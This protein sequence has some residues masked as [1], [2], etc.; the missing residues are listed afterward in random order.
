M[1][2]L[3]MPPVVYRNINRT[4]RQCHSEIVIA[5]DP[6]LYKLKYIKQMRF[7]RSELGHAYSTMSTT[8]FAERTLENIKS[9]RFFIE[10][11]SHY[12]IIIL[13]VYLPFCH[14][15]NLTVIKFIIIRVDAAFL[16][17]FIYSTFGTSMYKIAPPYIQI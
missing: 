4:R 16:T 17:L 15:Y 13:L 5:P 12:L 9:H 2:L 7:F 3:I 8:T 6:I 10:G 1:H 11:K 14:A